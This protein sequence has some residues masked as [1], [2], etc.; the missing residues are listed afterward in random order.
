MRKVNDIMVEVLTEMNRQFEKW[1]E[2]NHS[3]Y[4]WNGILMEEVGEASKALIE[5]ALR[6]YVGAVTIDKDGPSKVNVVVDRPMNSQLR[7]E[8]VQVAAVAMSWIESMDRREEKL[9]YNNGKIW[10]METEKTIR[11]NPVP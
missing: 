5:N 7:K 2:Q 4:Y 10:E 3:D 11:A 9:V 1:G 6:N 8:L